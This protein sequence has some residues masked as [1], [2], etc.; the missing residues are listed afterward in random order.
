MEEERE[1]GRERGI[2]GIGGEGKKGGREDEHPKFLRRGCAPV[3]CA[4]DNSRRCI[5]IVIVC[6]SVVLFR[7]FICVF[8]AFHVSIIPEISVMR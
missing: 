7:Q 5:R 3:H 6:H 1:R 4:S 2:I 8:C